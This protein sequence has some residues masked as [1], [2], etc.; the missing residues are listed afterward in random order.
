VAEKEFLRSALV[1]R[2]KRETGANSGRK[3]MQD[4][5]L[6]IHCT[7]SVHMDDAEFKSVSLLA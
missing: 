7:F 1:S 2:T 5:L 4:K 3:M 6:R